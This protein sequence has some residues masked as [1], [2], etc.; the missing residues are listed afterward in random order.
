LLSHRGDGLSPNDT[1]ADDGALI[2][3]DVPAT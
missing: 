1:L 2:V 3:A